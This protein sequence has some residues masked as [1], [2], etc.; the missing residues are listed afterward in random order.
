MDDQ[1]PTYRDAGV[2]IQAGEQAVELMRAAVKSTHSPAVISGLTDFGGMMGLG[3]AYVDPVL[4]AGTDSVGTKLKIAFALD[5]HDTVG[6]DCVAMCVDDIVCQGARPLLFLDYIGIG[7]LIPEV[8][9]EIVT[10]VAR[11]CQLAGCALLGGETA[12][13][14]DMYQEGE[15]DLVGFA[16]GV[17]ERSAIIDGS[18]VTAGDV[19]VGLPSSG[20][21]SNGYSL[22]RYVLLDGAEMPLDEEVPELGRTLGEELLEPT[23]IYAASLVKLLEGGPLP[24]AIMHITGGGIPGNIGRGIPEGLTGHVDMSSFRR[25]AIFDLIQ[26]TGG[27][28]EEEMRRTFNLGLG[29]VLAV[30]EQDA[31]AACDVLSDAGEEPLIVGE[32]RAGG[33]GGCALG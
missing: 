13:L 19:L 24:H 12:E 29:M 31:D 5:R 11:G 7:D 18:E 3:D 16:V 27:V 8:V 22:A 21:H 6:Q 23:R 10:G 17:M 14:G 26:R 33:P 32:V 20:L 9:A 30:G 2:D 15:Y 4:V 25:P 1:G 28:A